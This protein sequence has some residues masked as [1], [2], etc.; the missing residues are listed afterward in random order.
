MS[1]GQYLNQALAERFGV[2]PEEVHER[3]QQGQ[4][5]WPED[6]R[7][8]VQAA[9]ARAKG[10]RQ[11]F[12]AQ[13]LLQLLVAISEISVKGGP[14]LRR[15]LHGGIREVFERPP[16]LRARFKGIWNRLFR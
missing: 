4:C 3:F 8:R 6:F 10:T 11:T 1:L 7:V 2:T 14:E 12:D 15:V 16:T 5:E 9:R 13:L